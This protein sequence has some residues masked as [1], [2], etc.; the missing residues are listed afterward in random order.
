MRFRHRNWPYPSDVPAYLYWVKSPMLVRDE[1]G[2]QWLTK[3]LF[4]AENGE[5]HVRHVPWGVL[6]ELKLGS[7]YQGG[8]VMDAP[9]PGEVREFQLGSPVKIRKISADWI[10]TPWI[11]RVRDHERKFLY[12]QCVEIRDGSTVL[13]VPCV[14]I[15]RSFFAINKQL[16]Y[17]L[18]EPSGLT[19]CCTSTLEDGRATLDFNG[20][21]SLS[22]LTPTVVSRIAAILH[23]RRWWDCWQHVWNSSRRSTP[24][25]QQGQAQPLYLQLE[26]LPPI[27][28]NCLWSVRGEEFSGGFFVM[29]IVGVQT[30]QS[31][32][33]H[34]V[35]YTH[36]RLKDVGE[37]LPPRGTVAVRDDDAAE[38]E[39]DASTAGPR[40][41]S[42]PYMSTV[43]VTSIQ[44]GRPVQ[45]RRKLRDSE[46]SGGASPEE[47]QPARPNTGAEAPEKVSL[48][49]DGESGTVPAGEFHPLECLV[50]V[51]GGLRPFL[52]AV[53]EMRELE[54]TVSCDV[55]PV[56]DASRLAKLG[57]LARQFAIVQVVYKSRCGYLL[58]IDSSDGHGIST[59]VFAPKGNITA[60]ELAS[61]LLSEHLVGAGHWN[62]ASLDGC[63]GCRYDLAK[64]TSPSP[65][66]W[67]TRLLNKIITLKP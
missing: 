50:N 27:Y 31:L 20:E 32:P 2:T 6:P 61:A 56:P 17:L 67:G 13:V 42:D 46:D 59:M 28:D 41:Q 45:V 22:A 58:E 57:D 36:P 63:E 47:R 26:S 25:A 40:G 53:G 7:M 21:V 1:H 43:H 8:V 12:E 51:P 16:A 33:F 39:I 11:E 37:K 49:D 14:E 44:F 34:T 64:H 65:K 35:S 19:R 55:Q 60:L 3:I 38:A 48:N 10:R 18:L 29:E 9:P 52:A 54:A 15:I 24:E 66:F 5:P 62:L 23:H 30:R 4:M